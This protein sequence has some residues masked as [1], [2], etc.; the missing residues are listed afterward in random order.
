YSDFHLRAELQVGGASAGGICFRC[1][2]NRLPLQLAPGYKS[3]LSSDPPVGSVLTTMPEAKGG[4]VIAIASKTAFKGSTWFTIEVLARG[5][6]ITVK[7]NGDTVVA[8]TDEKSTYK[9]GRIALETY[10]PG[11]LITFKKI[12]IKELP[13]EETGFV[14]LFNGKDLDGWEKPD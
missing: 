11:T 3:S 2:L 1:G 9:R 4:K 5:N 14:Q 8:F 13:L 10:A 6:R 7:I 12:E